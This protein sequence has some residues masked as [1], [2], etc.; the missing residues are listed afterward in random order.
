MRERQ[1]RVDALR[2]DI[3]AGIRQLESG[4]YI[5]INSA[6]ELEAFFE[7]MATRIDEKSARKQSE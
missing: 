2:R 1:I 3:D 6:A 7:N 4:D 5:E